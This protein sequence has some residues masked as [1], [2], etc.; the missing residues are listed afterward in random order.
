MPLLL[1][2]KPSGSLQA[3]YNELCC[4]AYIRLYRIKKITRYV[5]LYLGLLPPSR[6]KAQSH[7]V[8]SKK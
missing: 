7:R 6:F 2:I 3:T 4:C 8:K 5:N 1:V